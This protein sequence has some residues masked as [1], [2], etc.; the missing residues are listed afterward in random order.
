AIVGWSLIYVERLYQ[1]PFFMASIF[2][3]FILPQAIA[4]VN[5]PYYMTP[6]ALER[7]LLYSALCVAMCW[8]G[9]QIKPDRQ[10]LQFFNTPISE[11]KL[12]NAGIVLLGIGYLCRFL[13]ARTEIQT[14]KV[15]TWTGTATILDFFGGVIFIAFPIFLIHALKNP[16]FTNFTVAAIAALPILETILVSGRR[17]NTM[18]FIIAIGLSLFF[19]KRYIPP[20]WF[21]VTIIGIGAYIIPTVG[22][23]RG[24]FWDLIIAGDW[25]GILNNSQVSLDQITEGKILELRNAALLMDASVNANEYTYGANFWNGI[26]FGYVPGQLVGYN[27]KQALQM[28]LPGFNLKTLYG[29]DL[30]TG[31]TVT[32]IGDSFVAFGYFGCLL[33]AAIAFLFRNLWT[34]SFY[35]Q[36]LISS[37]FY[38]SL[39]DSAMIGVTHGLSRFLNELI[40]KSIVIFLLLQFCREDRLNKVPYSTL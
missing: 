19:V 31:T 38:L 9:Y 7:V 25:Q 24:R 3:A 20:R 17:Q 26:I 14:T 29:Y 13:L 2:L 27:V 28:N 32:G 8:L 30:P 4:L 39:V 40:F 36:S 11:K 22:R 10:W 5:N 23:L 21:M 15:G 1:Y 35:N 6:T 16:I 34:S 18:T 33:F 37:L 12:F